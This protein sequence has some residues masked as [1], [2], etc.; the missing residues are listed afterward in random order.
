MERSGTHRTSEIIVYIFMIK[1][2]LPRLICS[3]QID[4]SGGNALNLPVSSGP[5][6]GFPT[7]F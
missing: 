3:C 5:G 6:P 1:P 7:D 4:K 2:C